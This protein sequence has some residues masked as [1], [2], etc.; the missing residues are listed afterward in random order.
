VSQRLA[1]YMASIRKRRTSW[2]VQIRRQGYPPLTKSFVYRTDALAWARNQE[3][4]IDRVEVPITH[5]GLRTLTVAELLDRYER[6][7]TVKKRGADRE[8]FKLR[9]LISHSI[10]GPVST[11]FLVRW[12][13]AIGTTVC[14]S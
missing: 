7:I 6:E 2:Q 9:V 4:A 11:W 14:K 13:P 10:A 3:R 8:R 1:G 12:S 5:R